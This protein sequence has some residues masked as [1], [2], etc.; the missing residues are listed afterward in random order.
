MK[1]HSPQPQV[2]LR[3]D[4]GVVVYPTLCPGPYMREIERRGKGS[5]GKREE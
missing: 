3:A 5:R 1:S 2:T 4:R